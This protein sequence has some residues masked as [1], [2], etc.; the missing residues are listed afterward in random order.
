MTFDQKQAAFVPAILDGRRNNCFCSPGQA[1]PRS[2]PAGLGIRLD[3]QHPLE[4]ADHSQQAEQCPSP[5]KVP[6]HSTMSAF[7]GLTKLGSLFLEL[8]PGYNLSAAP[9]YDPRFLAGW[10]A[11]VYYDDHVGCRPGSPPHLRRTGSP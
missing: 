7:P 8:L 2:L 10:P 3:R 5:V 9:A 1:P 4:R 6:P 11:E